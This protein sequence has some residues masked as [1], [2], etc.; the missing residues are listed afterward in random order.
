MKALSV[1]RVLALPALAGLAACSSLAPYVG[2]STEGG[3][4]SGRGIA[5]AECGTRGAP[6]ADLIYPPG[7]AE[8]VS[9]AETEDELLGGPGTRVNTSGTVR[10][11]ALAPVR[12]P[13]SA[14]SPPVEARCEA[15]FNLSTLGE[16][17]R[18]LV[19]CSSDMFV[20]EMT[21]LVSET[22][23]EPLRINGDL[24]RGVNLVFAHDFCRP[25]I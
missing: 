4:L 18:I 25:E 16:A 1:G 14:L 7:W 8:R 21:R 19:A 24:A 10:P 11:L 2:A 6:S 9:Q 13:A 3:A 22:R 12:Y 20:S 17:S 23:F 5:I 15:K